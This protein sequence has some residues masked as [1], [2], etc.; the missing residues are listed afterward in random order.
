MPQRWL[1][2]RG[3]ALSNIILR[4]GLMIKGT[5]EQRLEGGKKMGHTV[6]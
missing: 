6:A 1:E 4:L 5:G 2:E 3:A